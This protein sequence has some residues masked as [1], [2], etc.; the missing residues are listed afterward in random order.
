MS[1]DPFDYRC[2]RCDTPLL[3]DHEF[4][5]GTTCEQDYAEARMRRR[6]ALLTTR[7]HLR[8][9]RERWAGRI[10]RRIT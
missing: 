10:R 8:I 5:P 6:L 3:D 4:C 7:A 9:W 1:G 2:R